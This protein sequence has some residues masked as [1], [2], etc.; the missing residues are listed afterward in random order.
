MLLSC[1]CLADL[2]QMD[3]VKEDAFKKK[4]DKKKTQEELNALFKPVEQ[5]IAK[6]TPRSE[7]L[8]CK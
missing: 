4:E 2:L 3:K 5:K 8:K 1:Y 6:G 7:L